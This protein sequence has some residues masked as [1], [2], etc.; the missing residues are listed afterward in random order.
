MRPRPTRLDAVGQHPKATSS[1]AGARIHHPAPPLTAWENGGRR[2]TP[3]SATPRA[4]SPSRETTSGQHI[5]GDCG[6]GLGGGRIGRARSWRQPPGW[7]IRGIGF[8]TCASPECLP[9]QIFKFVPR[10]RG[11]SCPPAACPSDKTALRAAHG[12]HRP[13]PWNGTRIQPDPR[14]WLWWS[15]WREM[16]QSVR[17]GVLPTDVVPCEPIGDRSSGNTGSGSSRFTPRMVDWSIGEGVR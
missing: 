11:P 2:R 6:R 4:G 15:A 1:R 10:R 14:R 16:A 13:V 12:P 5:P 3:S 17:Q 9:G 8:P 7:R